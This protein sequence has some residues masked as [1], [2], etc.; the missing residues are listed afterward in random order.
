M[1][2]NSIFTFSSTKTM[3]YQRRV[4]GKEMCEVV[5]MKRG[6]GGSGRIKGGTDLL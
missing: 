2:I 4:V 1:Q 6:G 5:A 3:R